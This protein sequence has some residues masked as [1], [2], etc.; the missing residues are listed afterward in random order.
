MERK[1]DHALFSARDPLIRSAMNSTAS[2]HASQI[3]A[4]V[5]TAH[6]ADVPNVIAAM[7]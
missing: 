7:L 1:A 2:D 5:H 3:S 4:H 6:V